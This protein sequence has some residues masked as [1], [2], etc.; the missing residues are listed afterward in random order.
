MPARPAT[1]Q[2]LCLLNTNNKQEP[3]K[4][5]LPVLHRDHVSNGTIL[6]NGRGYNYLQVAAIQFMSDTEAGI[7]VSC[8]V[9]RKK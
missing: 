6:V 4:R 8:K 9:S 5:L 2:V 1:N 7:L 3:P